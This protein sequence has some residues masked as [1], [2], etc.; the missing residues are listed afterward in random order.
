[1]LFEQYRIALNWDK[2]DIVVW[3]VDAIKYNQ[4]FFDFMRQMFS[5]LDGLYMD[6]K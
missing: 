6:E 2:Y 3:D 1:M 5:C 4:I